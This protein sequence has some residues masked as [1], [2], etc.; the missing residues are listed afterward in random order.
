MWTAGIAKHRAFVQD[1]VET[2]LPVIGGGVF[3]RTLKQ[4]KPLGTELA[5]KQVAYAVDK[6][7]GDL[8]WF[9]D[10]DRTGW[11]LRST[12]EFPGRLETH[13]ERNSDRAA[14]QATFVLRPVTESPPKPEPTRA[15]GSTAE[16]RG[17]SRGAEAARARR[18]RPLPRARSLRADP[19]RGHDQEGRRLED[20]RGPRGGGASPRLHAHRRRRARYNNGRVPAS[21]PTHDGGGVVD[22]LA[23]DWKRKVRV[24]RSIGFAAWHRTPDQGP[25]PE[26]IHAVLIDHGRLDP[27]AAR[28]VD[29]VP[30]GTQR[31]RERRPGHVLAPGPDPGVPLPA[32][33]GGARADTRR[34]R[35]RR[36]PGTRTGTGTTPDRQPAPSVGPLPAQPDR[37]RRRREPLPAHGSTSPR[38]RPRGSGS[39]T[40]RPPRAAD[41]RTTRTGRRC[42]RRA[43]PGSRSARTTSPG[44]TSAT[45]RQE[46]MH[47]L[48]HA[49]IRA[50]DMVPM[51]DL[52]STEGLGPR[53]SHEVGRPLGR[54]G[55]TGAGQEGPR[56]QADHL[57]PLPPGRRVRLPV[58][59]GP[60]QH[61]R[62]RPGH[63]ERRGS[64]PRSGSTRTASSGRSR[65]SPASGR[66]T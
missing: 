65:A 34:H 56:L 16:R 11:H 31:P 3:N 61:R 39:C 55:R 1:L 62:P 10:G 7:A 54:H 43:R 37:R 60:L 25:W 64:G 9:I 38:V 29:C 40:P 42:G 35:S 28:Q 22:L 58:V 13:P 26:H 12:D 36:D 14:R 8:L 46:A 18:G 48:K 50:G 6:N 17:A 5:G 66:W 41:G 30:P 19:L 53:R 57:H 51:L 2:G 20:P 63:P 52:E 21:G 27:S 32:E 45:L 4:H 59:G 44:P 47:F 49:D 15:D 23:E 33:G 24:L